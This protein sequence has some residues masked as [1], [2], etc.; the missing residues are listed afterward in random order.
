MGLSTV[1]LGNVLWV[2]DSLVWSANENFRIEKVIEA[3][4][5]KS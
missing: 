4:K 2:D 3:A 5:I 1:V